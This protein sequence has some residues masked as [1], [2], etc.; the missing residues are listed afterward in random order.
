VIRFGTT[1]AAHPLVK[2][3][4][5]RGALAPFSAATLGDLKK[6]TREGAHSG[7][8]RENFYTSRI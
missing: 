4:A 3:I 2:N 6:E 1:L 8:L 5:A 7:T